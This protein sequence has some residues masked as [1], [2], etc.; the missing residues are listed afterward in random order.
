MLGS[1]AMDINSL[2]WTALGGIGS[3]CLNPDFSWWV[4][5][6]GAGEFSEVVLPGVG[7]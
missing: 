2:Y 1:V 7:L 4:R 3:G 5:P 6:S